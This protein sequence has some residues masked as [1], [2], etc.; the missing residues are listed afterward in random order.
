MRGPKEDEEWFVKC[1]DE[2][3]NYS[4]WHRDSPKGSLSIYNDISIRFPADCKH[5]R[6]GT[7]I[8]YE[9]APN[10]NNNAMKFFAAPHVKLGDIL[11]PL[12]LA[13]A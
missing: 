2:E 3:S 12:L 4:R 5:I 11:L 10:A 7:A 9:V 13:L 6:A 8:S 1:R